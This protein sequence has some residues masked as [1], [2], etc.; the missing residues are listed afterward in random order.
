MPIAEPF[1]PDDI[2]ALKAMILARDVALA[3]RDSL[4]QQQRDSLA[5]MKLAL[6]ARAL[7]IEHLKLQIAKLKRMQ[8]GRSSEKLDRKIEQLEARLEDLQTED[9]VTD[10]TPEAAE[11]TPRKSS[12]RRILP[13]HLPREDRIYEPVEV[14]CPECGGELKLLGEE[15][16]E[17][18]DIITLAFKAIRH[19]RRKKACVRCD[20]IV[21]G[22]TPTRPIERGMATPAVLSHIAISKF[23]H[24]IPLYRVSE[25]W[26]REGVEYDRSVMAR[27]LGL[28]C[29]LVRPLA[30]A[31]Q[32]YS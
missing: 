19:I 1:L 7:E 13:D 23:C 20:A 22:K 21:Q 24:H 18:L 5:Q 3:E 27:Q 11:P 8:F 17:Q 31:L 32:Q 15:I 4:L 14:A 29:T 6:Q 9:G 30:D 25:I 2:D 16:S 10:D 12:A 26:A 28:C